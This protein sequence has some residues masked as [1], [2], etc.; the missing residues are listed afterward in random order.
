MQNQELILSAKLSDHLRDRS[1]EIDCI[2]L[3]GSERSYL[4]SKIYS[5]HQLPCLVVVSTVKEAEI[6]I[7]DLRFFSGQPELPILFFPPYHILPFKFLSYHNE[8][9]GHRIRVLHQLMEFNRPPIVVTTVDALLQKIIPR[10]E[11]G[12]YVEL[13]IAE[14]EIDRDGLITKLIA[15]GYSKTAIVEEFGDF[16]VRGGIIDVFSPLY[17]DPLRIEFYGDMVESLRF[18]SASNQRKIKDI[19]EAIILPARELILNNEFIPSI[20]SSIRSISNDLDVPVSHARNIIDTIRH[21]QDVSGLESLLPIFYSRLDTLFDYTPEN[22]LIVTLNPEELEKTA[23]ET[24]DRLA[25]NYNASRDDK[26]LC[27]EPQELYLSWTQAAA[28][29]ADRKPLNFKMLDVIKS[30]D[31]R[32]LPPDQF[33]AKV[34]ANADLRLTLENYREKEQLLEPLVEWLRNKQLSGFAPVLISRNRTHA[35]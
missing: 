19:Q 10:Q 16:S 7:A 31:T 12:R 5:Q 2:G 26:K 11:I 4:I 13:L 15:G 3:S 17:D 9:A 34:E 8:T 18:F 28:T 22:A 32:Q 6:L 24:E 14:E 27:V 29:M 35:D 25:A 1:R 30:N 21:Q 23:L 20:I 33:H